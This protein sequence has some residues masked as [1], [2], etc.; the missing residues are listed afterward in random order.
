[1]TFDAWFFLS[2]VHSS[3]FHVTQPKQAIDSLV[4][5]E[6]DFPMQME[7]VLT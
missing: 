7:V 3:L 6:S 1:V 2:K 4:L 5:A